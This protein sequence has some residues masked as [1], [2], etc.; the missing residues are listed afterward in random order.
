MRN[1]ILR[2]IP[3]VQIK[4]N[5][6]YIHIRSGDI[7]L[8][9][10]NPNYAQPPLCFYQ[11]IIIENNYNNIYIF[12]NGHENPVIGNLLKLYSKVLYIKTS[13]EDAIS[14]I[15]NA[16]NFIKSS[17]TFSGTLI[18]LNINLKNLYIYSNYNLRIKN[19]NYKLHKMIPSKMYQQ[20]VIGKW[21]KTQEQLDLMIN[22]KCIKSKMITLSYN[23]IK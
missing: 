18:Q 13:V 23:A 17:S 7:F 10:I 3:E 11:K 6:L 2:N 22:E 9:D 8:N 14:L 21:K 5:D 19:I 4:P 15:I 12:S 1:E 16:Y 20:N